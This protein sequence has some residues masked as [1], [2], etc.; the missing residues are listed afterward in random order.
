MQKSPFLLVPREA[1]RVSTASLTA[2]LCLREAAA[3]FKR[4]G[5]QKVAASLACDLQLENAALWARSPY[6]FL[7]AKPWVVSCCSQRHPG[8]GGEEKHR[9]AAEPSILHSSTPYIA[10]HPV[11]HS[12]SAAFGSILVFRWKSR[13]QPSSLLP[14]APLGTFWLLGEQTGLGA[15]PAEEASCPRCWQQ[16][17]SFFPC[18]KYGN[19]V[20]TRSELGINAIAQ[21]GES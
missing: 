6:P 17:W 13:G 12:R 21:I 7:E 14:P 11:C 2:N 9:G 15:A 10:P 19:R 4:E 8:E 3:D 20:C 18:D 5:E 1:G 16:P